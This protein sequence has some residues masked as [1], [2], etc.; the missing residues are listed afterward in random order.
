M[1]K[2]IMR[3]GSKKEKI[4]ENEVKQGFYF[5]SGYPYLQKE[6]KVSL[7]ISGNVHLSVGDNGLLNTINNTFLDCK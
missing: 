4:K 1:I 7:K 6:E 3:T 5:F 2:L